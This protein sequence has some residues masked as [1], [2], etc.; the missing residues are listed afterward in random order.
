M[1]NTF[2]FKKIKNEIQLI[3]STK[4]E[5][6]SFVRNN[7][8]AMEWTAVEIEESISL[9]DIGEDHPIAIEI[10]DNSNEW[11]V[12]YPDAD[13]I[14]YTQKQFEN[15]DSLSFHIDDTELYFKSENDLNNEELN[16]IKK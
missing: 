4:E 15:Q 3:S 8:D 11:V 6:D 7:F 2:G 9:G 12:C 13:N 10:F 16:L 14:L 1:K 5:F